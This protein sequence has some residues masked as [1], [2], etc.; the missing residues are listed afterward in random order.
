MSKWADGIGRRFQNEQQKSRHPGLG[1]HPI[2]KDKE[3][4]N[5]YQW[6]NPCLSYPRGINRHVYPI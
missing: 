1:K 5:H 2:S 6:N 4:L 3:V